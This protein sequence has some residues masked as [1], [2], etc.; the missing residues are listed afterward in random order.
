M[1]EAT[2]SPQNV[3]GKAAGWSLLGQVELES[4]VREA[5]CSQ[6]QN[7]GKVQQ[8]P[9]AR[10]GGW[11]H[12]KSDGVRAVYGGTSVSRDVTCWGQG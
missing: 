3:L 7:A 4:W 10:E 12:T 1:L 11:A 9:W 2:L 5:E 8:D 6:Q